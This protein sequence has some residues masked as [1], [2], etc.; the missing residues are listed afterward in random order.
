[1][2]KTLKELIKAAKEADGT[3]KQKPSF[4]EVI[5]AAKREVKK[6]NDAMKQANSN[7]EL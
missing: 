1:M 3:E 5:A 6:H 2:D 4:E 7:K